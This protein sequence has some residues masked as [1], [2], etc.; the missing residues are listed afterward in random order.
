[1]SFYA[2]H[3][4]TGEIAEYPDH[5][6]NHP[7]LGAVLTEVPKPTRGCTDCGLPPVKEEP[8]TVERGFGPDEDLDHD[9]DEY[10]NTEAVINDDGVLEIHY[11]DPEK[12]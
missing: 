1:M 8:E 4:V 7:V 2:K 11:N 12:D 3:E 6:R 9:A 10:E 5:Y